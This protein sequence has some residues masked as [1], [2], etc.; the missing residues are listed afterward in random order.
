MK[1]TLV[2][3]AALLSAAAP[4]APGPSAAVADEEVR[5]P[6]PNYGG[7][8]NFRAF[9]RDTI[10]VQ[11]NRRNWYRATLYGPCEGLPNA[12]RIGVDTRGSALDRFSAFIVDGQRCQIESLVRSGEP[13]HR[14]RRR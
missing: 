1:S 2:M 8:R 14:K 9:D 11:D 13:P 12:L 3:T 10:Y 4:A 7:V 5:I 6:F